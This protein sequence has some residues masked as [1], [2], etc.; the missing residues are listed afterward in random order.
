[1]TQEIVAHF[2]NNGVPLTAP[3]TVPTI[4]IRRTDTGAL[5]VTD[6]AMTELGDGTFRF[7]FTP[8]A[9]LLEYSVR[10][11]GDPIAALQVSVAD[12]YKY[13]AVGLDIVRKILLNRAV[14]TENAGPVPPAGSKTVDFYDDDQVTIV[15]SILISADGLERTNP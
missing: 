8:A 10:A 14:T 6:A 3:A 9:V 11:D 2:T 12:R 13:G 15:D 5:V 7:T 1:M 4:R